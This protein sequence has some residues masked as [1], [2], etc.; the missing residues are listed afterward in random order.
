MK[1]FILNINEKKIED[2]I[3][4]KT[5]NG[6]VDSSLLDIL[7]DLYEYKLLVDTVIK[8]TYKD[9]LDTYDYGCKKGYST[10]V[11][12]QKWRLLNCQPKSWKWIWGCEKL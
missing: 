5:Y 12:Y 1:R 8:D 2:T 7:N 3:S 6:M 10:V 4:N 9:L 11:Q